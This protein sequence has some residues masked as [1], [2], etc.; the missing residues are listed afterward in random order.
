MGYSAGTACPVS[1]RL[2]RGEACI[3]FSSEERAL[4]PLAVL[5]GIVMGSAAALFIG[6]ALTAIVFLLLPEFQERFAGEWRPLGVGI[7]LTAILTALAAASFVA[8]IRERPW[9]RRVQAVLA[10]ALA[11]ILWRYWPRAGG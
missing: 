8:E 6:L 11:L 10:L 3:K 5:L 4:R 9:R 2:E 7:A 1:P